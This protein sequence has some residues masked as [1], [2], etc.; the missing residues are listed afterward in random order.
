MPTASQGVKRDREWNRR[1]RKPVRYPP[2]AEVSDAGSHG[3]NGCYDPDGFVQWIAEILQVLRPAQADL[4]GALR[5]ALI[6]PA[7]AGLGDLLGVLFQSMNDASY[8]TQHPPWVCA[9]FC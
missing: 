4:V 9:V 6:R 2:R 3:E 1:V 7:T 8:N 5:L